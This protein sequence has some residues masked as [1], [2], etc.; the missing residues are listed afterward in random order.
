MFYKFE[1]CSNP[2]VDWQYIWKKE[3]NDEFC[4]ALI[5]SCEEDKWT[6]AK[7]GGKPGDKGVGVTDKKIRSVMHQPLKMG[8][9]KGM[10]RFPYNLLADRIWRAN[11]EVWRLDIDG[12]NLE[13]DPPNI[14]RYKVE[15]AGHYDWHLDYGAEFSNRKISFI[16]QLSNSN[17]YDG[18][19][20][21][22][23]GCP[24]EPK[25]RERGTLIMFPSYVRH[26]ITHITRGMRYCVVGWIHGPHFR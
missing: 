4:D 13:T 6:D 14:L 26:R 25:M 10:G 16:L 18:C 20:L 22:L 19:N 3:F 11:S 1:K 24:P 7:V 5:N 8:T 21:E 9:Y 17:D 2:R 15:E 23:M 12:F